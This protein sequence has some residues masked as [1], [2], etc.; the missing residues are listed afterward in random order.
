MPPPIRQTPD[1]RVHV[2]PAAPRKIDLAFPAALPDAARA[3]AAQKAAEQLFATVAEFKDVTGTGTDASGKGDARIPARRSAVATLLAATGGVDDAAKRLEALSSNVQE[4]I[5]WVLSAERSDYDLADQEA[6][7]WAKNS[8]NGYGTASPLGRFKSRVETGKALAAAVERG[9]KKFFEA[10]DN[11]VAG[12]ALISDP[13]KRTRSLADTVLQFRARTDAAD[14]KDTRID[15]HG[16]AM[17]GEQRMLLAALDLDSGAPDAA[18]EYALVRE[19]V[20]SHP[21]SSGNAIFEARNAVAGMYMAEAKNYWDKTHPTAWVRFETP[22]GATASPYASIHHNFSRDTPRNIE[23]FVKHWMFPV[24]P[25]ADRSQVFVQLVDAL[26]QA[27]AGDVGSARSTL[28]RVGARFPQTMAALQ[29]KLSAV[30]DDQLA[31]ALFKVL[32]ETCEKDLGTKQPEKT[33]ELAARLYRAVCADQPT[34]ESLEK[35]LFKAGDAWPQVADVIVQLRAG[36]GP[37][38]LNA[39]GEARLALRDA[40]KQATTGFE[41][42]QIILFDA[43]LNRLACEELG[44]AVD[45]VGSLET[46][47][48]KTEALVALR[49]ALQGAV[50]SGLHAV[51]DDLDPAA[52]KGQSLEQV[53]AR[54]DEVTRSGS[55]SEDEYRVLMSEAKVAVART[56]QNIRSFYDARAGDLTSGGVELDPMFADQLV[57]QTPLHYATALAEK[58]MR[59][60][61]REEQ[62][63]RHIANIEGMRVLNSVGPVVFPTVVVA[64][65]SNDLVKLN[66]PRDALCVVYKSDEKK[67]KMAG[68]LVVDTEDAPGGNSHLNMYAMNNGIPVIAL[69]ELSTRYVD[70]LANAEAEGGLY[71]DDRNGEFRMMTVAHAKEQGLLTDESAKGLLPGTNRKIDFLKPNATE[72]G[73]DLVATHEVEVSPNRPTRNIELYIPQDEVKGVGRKALSFI[74]LSKLGRLG[75]HLAGEKGLVLSLLKGNPKLSKYVPDGSIVTTGRVKSLLREAGIEDDWNRIWMADP[76]VGRVDD[77]NF[78]QSAFY[79]DADYRNGAREALLTATREG[80]TRHL[81]AT[82]GAGNKTLTPAGEALLGE[83]MDNPAL[84]QSDNWIARS[85]YT[86]EDRP[87]KSGA[88]Q[89]ESFYNLKD[90]VARIEGII[91]VIESAW[92]GAPVENNVAEEVNLQHIMPSIVVQHCLDPDISGVMISRNI[93]NGARSQVSYQLVKGFGGGV[94]GGKT[95]EGLITPAGLSTEVK[96]PGE[97]NGLAPAP[98]MEELRQVVVNV[99]Q[100][101]NDEIEPGKGH[102]VDMEVA[103]VGDQWQ[104][105]QARVILIDK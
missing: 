19:L 32:E 48:Q 93:D 14:V 46:D 40:V 86:G 68:G 83:L 76:K 78:L 99:E 104:V 103:R 17:I 7:W 24:G 98:A 9:E 12:L 33:L 55:V 72:D 56:V 105:V 96:Y 81:I 37:G 50:A 29:P 87:G 75:R 36:N 49:S 58:G 60:G 47:G 92:H 26:T 82:D 89:Y 73:F 67:M 6:F 28:D 102:A 3:A 22:P 52:Q 51:K 34:V 101:F 95:E 23:A 35:S 77:K 31:D 59:V 30:A 70:L 63:S 80:L 1:A 41:R 97:P 4:D 15:S 66:P 57:K 62:S 85:S 71:V 18:R 44:A 91:G 27:R 65:N 2:Q 88:G 21:L 64:A 74:D 90:P 11:G 5:K 38:A 13:E 53:L 94:E 84:A 54:I 39:L 20:A 100:F 25:E 42:H 79:T 10:A 16:P 69:P 8:M 61:L 43:A 45:R